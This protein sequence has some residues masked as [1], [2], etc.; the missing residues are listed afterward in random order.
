MC[1]KLTDASVEG[2]CYQPSLSL[3]DQGVEKERLPRDDRAV[4]YALCRG[5]G[6]KRSVRETVVTYDPAAIVQTALPA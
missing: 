2:T 4:Q 1:V 3:F 6:I 5:G